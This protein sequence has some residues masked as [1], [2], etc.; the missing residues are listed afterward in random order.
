MDAAG[1][2][3]ATS[4]STPANTYTESITDGL[5]TAAVSFVAP[6]SGLFYVQVESAGGSGSVTNYYVITKR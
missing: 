4:T 1:L 2:P 3:L 5:P 6:T